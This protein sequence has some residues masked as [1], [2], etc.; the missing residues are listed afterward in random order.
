VH[1]GVEFR[2]IRRKMDQTYSYG[3]Q[4][5]NRH[6][7]PATNRV[8]WS[9]QSARLQ[10]ATAIESDQTCRSARVMHPRPIEASSSNVGGF[11]QLILR[12]EDQRQP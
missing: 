5:I 12:Y 4:L 3:N 11:A 8:S 9:D 7:N 1:F 6:T 10:P 2:E